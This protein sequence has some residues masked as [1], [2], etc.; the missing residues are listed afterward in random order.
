MR[1]L[2]PQRIEHY[3]GAYW[4]Q[5]SS[6]LTK[7]SSTQRNE[8]SNPRVDE[9]LTSQLVIFFV[10]VCCAQ[11]AV[12]NNNIEL[13]VLL[14]VFLSTHVEYLTTRQSNIGQIC[15][16]FQS[17]PFSPMRTY[18]SPEQRTSH[19]PP[20][21]CTPITTQNLGVHLRLFLGGVWRY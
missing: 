2:S 1:P 6:E 10:L 19:L 4:K 7:R 18:L 20:F 11:G 13:L 16:A 21:I 3:Y 12:F 9:F 8:I 5:L 17:A 15:D 14:F